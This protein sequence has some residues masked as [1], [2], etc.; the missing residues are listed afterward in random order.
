MS[1]IRKIT[2][3]LLSMVMLVCCFTAPV[4]AASIAD[5]ATAISSGKEYSTKLY[6]YR[7]T[8]D[9]K[10]TAAKAGD[11]TIDITSQLYYTDIYVY[12]SDGNKLRPS[13]I[14]TTSGEASEPYSE[15]HIQCIWN[16][17]V[18]KYSGKLTY[19]IKKGTY[20]IRFERPL[21]DT[22]EKGNG[23]IN[24]SVTVPTNSEKKSS[25]SYLQITIPKGS[26]MQ[27]SAVGT[28]ANGDK[29][30]WSSSKTSVATISSKG[31]VTAKAA[32]TALITAKL[33]TSIMMLRIKVTN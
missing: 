26:T 12:D 17:A 29:L 1:K 6:N 11:L 9:F 27:F 23:K 14:K 22:A 20:Y 31:V 10:I 25:I 8:K 24:F 32:G 13:E 15:K 2:A 33:G 7:D 5:T 21:Y 19:G 4:S 16:S 3:V 18:E 28:V 30:S